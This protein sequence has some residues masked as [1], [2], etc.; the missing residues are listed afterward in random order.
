[1]K[2]TI[3]YIFTLIY[4]STVPL[5]GAVYKG[6]REFS[7]NCLSCHVKPQ[8]FIVTYTMEEW[9]KK[10][11]NDGDILAKL[12]ISNE[13]AKESWSYFKSGRYIR[14]LKHLRDFLVEFAKDSGNVPTCN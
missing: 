8:E 5:N 11:D 12:H 10:L 1:M 4:L 6:Q 2:K 9:T 14:K 7:K 13:K 3:L